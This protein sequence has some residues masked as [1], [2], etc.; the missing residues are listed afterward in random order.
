M[1]LLAIDTSTAATVVAVARDDGTLLASR[2]HDPAAPADGGRRRPQPQHTTQGL[3]L[4][5]E[6]LA[7]AQT[8]WQQLTRIGVGVGPGSFTGLRSG[9]SAGAALAARLGVPAVALRGP[10]L[11]AQ[12]AGRER[13]LLTV[14]DGRRGE[15]F[16]ERFAAGAIAPDVLSGG[17]PQLIA[18]AGAGAIDRL[19]G[20]L[21]IGDGA[22]LASEALRAAGAEVPPAGD[23]RHRI[24]AA[25]L[26]ALT[27]AAP[28]VEPGQL[29]PAYGREPD[30]V[31]TAE[32]KARR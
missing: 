14:I 12:G 15:L 24:D 20:V 4:A 3:A 23:P 5:A 30:A 18:L 28:G 32:R 9:L 1:T 16:V 27:A 19:A 13:E 25:A 29:R 31:P 2:R 6:A 26:A 21:A 22:V 8:T 7:E 17:A 11:L 10:A